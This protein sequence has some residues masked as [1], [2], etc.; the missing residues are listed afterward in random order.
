MFARHVARDVPPLAILSRI[1][2]IKPLKPKI[3][4]RRV[5]EGS[6]PFCKPAENTGISSVNIKQVIESKVGETSWQPQ[7]RLVK[8]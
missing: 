1:K 4:T 6:R 2:V 8:S 3:N 5:Q 7:E